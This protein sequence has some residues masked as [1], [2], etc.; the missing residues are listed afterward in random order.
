M[1]NYLLSYVPY[2]IILLLGVSS[3]IPLI[4]GRA[5]YEKLR[6]RKV[7]PPVIIAIMV[8]GLI[9]QHYSDKKIEGKDIEAKAQR[10]QDRDL[11]YLIA[12]E[13]HKPETFPAS[14]DFHNTVTM[15]IK[16]RVIHANGQVDLK[17]RTE[18]LYSGINKFLS[19]REN[20]A[21]PVP[22]VTTFEADINRLASYIKATISQYSLKFTP[23][24]IAIRN[25]FASKGL[26]DEQL[27]KYYEH[28]NNLNEIH[29]VVERIKA[30]AGRVR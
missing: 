27:D 22:A 21:P 28:P 2:I 9:N 25:E 18:D 6:L 29:I 11:L 20:N 12:K 1:L 13:V 4:K 7:I 30:L 16:T 26:R 19:D 14:V 5:I 23:Q 3:L 15:S 17:D 10:E 24:V 8:L